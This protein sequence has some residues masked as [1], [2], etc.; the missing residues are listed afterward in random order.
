MAN[1]RQV[2]GSLYLYS[3]TNGRQ[4]SEPIQE[5]LDRLQTEIQQLQQQQ[6][7]QANVIAQAQEALNAALV[8]GADTVGARR[9]L[10]HESEAL[11]ALEATAA[12]TLSLLTEL[13]QARIDQAAQ[14]RTAEA[15][16]GVQAL[17]ARYEI[18]ELASGS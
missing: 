7:D 13:E 16:A 15:Q 10:R 17:L 8:A 18:E 4:K 2:N 11:A 3:R 9:A 1:V 5:A 12:E 14:R 6:S